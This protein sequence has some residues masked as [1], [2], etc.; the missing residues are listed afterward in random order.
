MKIESDKNV[1]FKLVMVAHTCN[2]SYLEGGDQEDHSLRS[3]Q[4]KI[5]ETISKT[6]WT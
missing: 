3:V 2:S 5:I 6:S 1:Y 4:A